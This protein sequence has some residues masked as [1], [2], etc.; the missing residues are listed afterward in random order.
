MMNHHSLLRSRR[1]ENI[2]IGNLTYV[3]EWH[4]HPTVSTQPSKDDLFLLSSIKNY[5]SSWE[6][7]DLFIGIE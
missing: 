1:I 7:R 4:S 6:R 5:T 2:T 3:G